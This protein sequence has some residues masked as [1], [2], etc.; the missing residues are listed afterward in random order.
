MKDES[1]GTDIGHKRDEEQV[2]KTVYITNNWEKEKTPRTESSNTYHN[3]KTSRNH[4]NENK[5]RVTD[6]ITDG[7]MKPN[8]NKEDGRSNEHSTAYLIIQN[9]TGMKN[10]I[11]ILNIMVLFH[12]SSKMK[13]IL[14]KLARQALPALPSQRK[15]SKL[16][17]DGLG[18][19][20]LI[21]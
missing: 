2:V 5:K 11:T 17:D 1:R 8:K 6:I 14:W 21:S 10:L 20:L 7:G 4:E 3:I 15:M 18:R 19:K 16:S 13:K 12:Y 9:Q